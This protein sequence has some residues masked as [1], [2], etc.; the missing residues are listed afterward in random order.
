M[1]SESKYSY[2]LEHGM[3][4][5]R[6]INYKKDSFNEHYHENKISEE[7]VE[8]NDAFNPM[9]KINLSIAYGYN[10]L[11]KRLCDKHIEI[12]ELFNLNTCIYFL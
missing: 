9:T 11:L 6:Y 5:Y 4:Y 12:I 1:A 7:T 3:S 10:S 8:N 2:A